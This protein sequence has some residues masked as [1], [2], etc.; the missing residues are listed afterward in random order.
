MRPAS[1]RPTSRICTYI[2]AWFDGKVLLVDRLAKPPRPGGWVFPGGRLEYA[3]TIRECAA[4]EFAEEVG[5]RLPADRFRHLPIEP[6][7]HWR[8]DGA[9]MIGIGYTVQLGPAEAE[10]ARNMEPENHGDIHFFPLF[11]TPDDDSLFPATLAVLRWL[12]RIARE[13]GEGGPGPGAPKHGPLDNGEDRRAVG[14]S[15]RRVGREDDPK[16][17]IVV[18][19]SLSDGSMME[20]GREFLSSN[21]STHWNIE[22]WSRSP[23]PATCP[24]C[25]G[26]GFV[27]NAFGEDRPCPACWPRRPKG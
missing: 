7:E 17:Q 26:V 4:R 27:E 25:S 11:A 13:E 8:S 22:K 14:V 12:R 19:L 16:A 3:E 23:K 21:F 2:I 24:T 6:S 20:L 1:A 15:I 18:E 10:A 9:H 5:L